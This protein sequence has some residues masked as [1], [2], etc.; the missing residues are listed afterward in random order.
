MVGF[1]WRSVRV[2]GGRSAHARTPARPQ[3]VP[4]G[5]AKS[6]AKIFK[7]KCATCH[8]YN[9]VSRD[10]APCRVPARPRPER[11]G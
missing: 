4:D 8:T 7:V 3:G 1:A 11:A 5:D 2:R 9:A 6:G 10:A